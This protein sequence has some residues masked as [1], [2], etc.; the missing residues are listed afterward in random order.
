VG[1]AIISYLKDA[2]PET[3]SPYLFV[4]LNFPFVPFVSSPQALYRIITGYIGKAGIK[5][6]G[7]SKIGIHS[8][9]HSVANTLLN[10]NV[11]I[12]TIAD[13][14]GHSSPE[15]TL[16]YLRS[17]IEALSRCPLEV[18]FSED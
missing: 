9:R 14:L 16:H 1:W 15:T 5:T 11:G 4:R 7:R 6:E 2:R 12:T 18:M 13:I 8:L 10:H 3:A 17:S